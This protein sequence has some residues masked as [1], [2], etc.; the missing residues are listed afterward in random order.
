[1]ANM[2]IDYNMKKKNEIKKDKAYVCVGYLS[3]C[4]DERLISSGVFFNN[5]STLYKY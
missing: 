5:P 4:K 3:L 1:M 2:E